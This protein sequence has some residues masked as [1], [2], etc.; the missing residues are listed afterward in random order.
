QPYGGHV[1][2]PN[3]FGWVVE[4]DP[5]DPRSKPVKRTAF[6]RYCRECA[7]LSLGEDGRMAYYSGDDT[8]GEYIYKFVPDGRYVPGADQANRRLLDSGTL[9]VARFDADG[10]GRWLAPVHG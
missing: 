5:F 3:R 10:S 2:E 6:G 1:H 7:V 4:V 8:K 9:Y